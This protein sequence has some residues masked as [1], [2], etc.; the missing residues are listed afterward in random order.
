MASLPGL[1]TRL[2]V[3]DSHTIGE[4]TRVV[5][6]P[7]LAAGLDLG[8]GTIRQRRDA[9]RDRYDHVRRALVGDPRGADA[10]VGVVLLPPSDPSCRFGVIYMNRVGYLDMCGHAT[11]GLAVTLG[12]TGRI[13][14]GPFRLETPAGLVAVDWHGGSE[15]SFEN[16]TPRRIHRGLAVEVDGGATVTGDVATAGLWFFLC[17]DHGLPVVPATIPQLTG[18]RVGDPSWARC[19]RH[20]RGRWRSDRPRRAARSTG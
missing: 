11:I 5:I 16:V 10:M 13:A 3:V 8:A 6:D 17:S 7:S 15:A 18:V 14:P 2:A 20:P 9:F 12:G 1:P 19:P 4:P